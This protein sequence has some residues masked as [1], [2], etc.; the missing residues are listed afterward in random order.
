MSFSLLFSLLWHFCVWDVCR[1]IH[2]A[3]L[4]TNGLIVQIRPIYVV[5]SKFIAPL[6][7]KL[8]KN[9]RRSPN[10]WVF[11]RIPYS[12]YDAQRII[13]FMWKDPCCMTCIIHTSVIKMTDQLAVL[14]TEDEPIVLYGTCCTAG[15]SP[16]YGV[17]SPRVA[18]QSWGS[19]SVCTAHEMAEPSTVFVV[20]RWSEGY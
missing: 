11:R 7:I 6:I 8:R 14:S 13:I 9:V 1:P 3:G 4:T 2:G 12:L 18:K 5:P 20:I 10:H 16:C 19:M 17:Q 15:A